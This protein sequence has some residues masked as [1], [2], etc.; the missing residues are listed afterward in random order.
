[1][2][3]SQPPV[4]LKFGAPYPT[5][6]VPL[7]APVAPLVS[8]SDLATTVRVV[9]SPSLPARPVPARVPRVAQ[10]RSR[11]AKATPKVVILLSLAVSLTRRLEDRLRSLRELALAAQPVTSLSKPPPLARVSRAP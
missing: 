10:S 4:D 9:L 7:V 6:V 3:I 5:S 2:Q 11:L 1:M 8:L